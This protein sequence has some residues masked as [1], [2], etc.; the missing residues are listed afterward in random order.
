MPATGT[1]RAEDD[2]FDTPKEWSDQK[3]RILV[4][5]LKSLL[6]IRGSFHPVIYYVDGY[7]GS[8]VYGRSADTE[9]AGSPILVAEIAEDVVEAPSRSSLR[10]MAVEYKP[11]RFQTLCAALAKYPKANVK[12]L[13]GDFATFLPSILREIGSAPAFFFIDPFGVK[14][15][16]PGAIDSLLQ[17]DDTELLL[18]FNSSR[19][20][21][22]AGFEDSDAPDARKKIELVST[23]LGEDPHLEVPKWMQ[24]LRAFGGNGSRWVEWAVDQYSE[25]LKAKSPHLNYVVRF[26]VRK[27]YNGRPV[28]HLLFATRSPKALPVMNDLCVSLEDE[29]FDRS[30]GAVTGQQTLGLVADYREMERARMATDLAEEICAW[31]CSQGI[32]SRERIF[33]EMVIRR[34]AQFKKRHYRKIIDFLEKEGRVSYDPEDKRKKDYRSLIFVK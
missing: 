15:I 31:G 11:D 14:D 28:Y 23:I 19:L 10:C 25:N 33:E 18:M 34:P 20:M 27:T 29:L 3:H 30:W 5:Y 12:P 9:T 8:G 4:D 16:R 26:P 21:K 2:F 7:A 22:L 32:T 1:T 13:Q 6:N 24:K 17:R